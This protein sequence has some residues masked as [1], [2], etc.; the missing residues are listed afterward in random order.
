MCVYWK[1]ASPSH[2]VNEIQV[3]VLRSYFIQITFFTTKKESKMKA[4][5]LQQKFYT[6]QFFFF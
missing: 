4:R 3:Y 5:F 2:N 1:A 6:E